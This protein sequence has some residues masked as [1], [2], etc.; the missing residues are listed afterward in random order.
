M[1]PRNSLDAPRRRLVRASH[2]LGVISSA[3]AIAAAGLFVLA[4]I[5][6]ARVPFHTGQPSLLL[7]PSTV[8]W[9]IVAVLVTHAIADVVQSIAG[10]R[11]RAR[12]FDPVPALAVAVG[13]VL[14][15]YSS[16]T[17]QPYLAITGAAFATVGLYV[18]AYREF[19]TLYYRAGRVRALRPGALPRPPVQRTDD[20]P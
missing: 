16:I 19:D 4:L 14:L 9:A 5:Q 8:I 6:A 20:T 1:T 3:V 15:A 2:L 12:R 11:D 17:L 10:T 7:V 18:V 13:T